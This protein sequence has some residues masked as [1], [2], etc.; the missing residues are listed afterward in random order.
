MSVFFTLL[1]SVLFTS[2]FITDL[3]AGAAFNSVSSEV[4]SRVEDAVYEEVAIS[5]GGSPLSDVPRNPTG[6][7]TNLTKSDMDNFIANYYKIDEYLHPSEKDDVYIEPTEEGL[8]SVLNQYGVSGD[9][10]LLKYDMIFD[11]YTVLYEEILNENQYVSDLK[12]TPND[13]YVSYWVAI[14]ECRKRTNETDM[15]VVRPYRDTLS[16]II[17]PNL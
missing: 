2:C 8:K 15:A 3:L 1:V 16:T 10:A 4:E 9:N 7:V 5:E 14:D 12:G 13:P 17:A 11:C 6:K